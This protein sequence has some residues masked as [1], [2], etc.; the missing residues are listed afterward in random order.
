MD[1]DA[2]KQV[3][4]RA[5]LLATA[6][7]DSNDAVIVQ[8]FDGR[9]MA[10]NRGAERLYGYG[11]TEAVA[12]NFRAIMPEDERNQPLEYAEHAA[13]GDELESL[14]GKRLT[15]DRRVLAY[16]DAA[17]RRGRKSDRRGHDRA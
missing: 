14:E 11:E 15:K 4:A 12:M 7:R 13:R 5:R 8:D 1:I 10:W 9:I 2:L 3:G 6:V 17:L 16:R